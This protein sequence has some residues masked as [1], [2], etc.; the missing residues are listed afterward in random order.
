MYAIIGWIPESGEGASLSVFRD[1]AGAD[2]SVLP[3]ADFVK[4][5]M[6]EFLIQKPVVIEVACE[7]SR[8]NA[9]YAPPRVLFRAA[10]EIEILA[11]TSPS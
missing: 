7:S 2:E 6:S 11:T 5:N 1:K 3:A 4:A 8:L 9:G 10:N